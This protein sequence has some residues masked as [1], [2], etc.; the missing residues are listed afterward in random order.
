MG[1]RAYV[2]Y[3]K[4]IKFEGVWGKQENRYREVWEGERGNECKSFTL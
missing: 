3:Q 2:D 4:L 1:Y